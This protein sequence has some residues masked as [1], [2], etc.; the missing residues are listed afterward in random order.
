MR[1]SLIAIGIAAALPMALLVSPASAEARSWHDRADAR[2]D[3]QRDLREAERDYRR[4]LRRADSR[5]DVWKARR[6]YERDLREARRDY[7]RDLKRSGH[8]HD[9]RYYGW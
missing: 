5:R 4:D 1:K 6:D 9:R 3:Y 2:R 8:R 7:Y